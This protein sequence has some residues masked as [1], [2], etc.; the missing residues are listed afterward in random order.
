MKKKLKYIGLIIVL[1]GMV[2]AKNKIDSNNKSR[3]QMMDSFDD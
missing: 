2:Y 3:V 1:I